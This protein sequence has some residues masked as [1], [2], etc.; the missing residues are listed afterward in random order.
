MMM[1]IIAKMYFQLINTLNQG[2]RKVLEAR[3]QTATT[4]TWGPYKRG[5]Q[6]MFA[7]TPFRV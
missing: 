7:T 2:R 5:E 6:K 4:A 3:G 1:R